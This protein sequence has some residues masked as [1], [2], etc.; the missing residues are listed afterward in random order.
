MSNKKLFSSLDLN[1]KLVNKAE[2]TEL[3]VPLVLGADS[4]RIKAK[5]L[6]Q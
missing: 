2:P 6:D 4:C 1:F 5:V 3:G